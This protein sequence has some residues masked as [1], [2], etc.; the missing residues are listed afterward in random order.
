MAIKISNVTVIDNDRKLFTSGGELGLP[1]TIN[2]ASSASSTSHLI[3]KRSGAATPTSFGAYAGNWRS[4]IEV[5]N[6]DSTRMLFLNPPDIATGEENYAHVKSVGGGIQFGVGSNGSTVPLRL[7][8]AGNAAFYGDT[9]DVVG[10]SDQQM[11]FTATDNSWKYIGFSRSDVGRRSYFG[12]DNSGNPIWGSDSGPFT[13]TGNY[14][15]IGTATHSPIF[16]DSNNTTYYLDPDAAVSGYSLFS[17]GIVVAGQGGFQSRSYNAGR[18]RIWSFNNA[19]GYGISYFQGSGGLNGSDSIGIHFGNAT[20][21]TSVFNFATS[22]NALVAKASF[23]TSLGGGASSS[24]KHID[25]INGT[26]YD[27]FMLPRG[28]L[29][30]YNPIVNDGDAIIGFSAGSVNTGA[31]S[32]I[33]WSDTASGIRLS[34]T[35]VT[36]L[37]SSS[38]NQLSLIGND[39]WAGIGWVDQGGSDY[40]WYRGS[41]ST[42]SIGGS[43]SVV[44]GKKLHING[45]TSIGNTVGGTAV[46]ANSLLVEESV[47]AR[48]FYD[49]DNTNYYTD[50]ADVSIFN[51]VRASKL[52][53]T[54]HSLSSAYYQGGATPTTG[55][56]ITTDI[57]YTS[58]NMPTVIIEGYAYGSAVPIHLEIVW[59]SYSDTFV[60]QSYT[61]LG[62]WHPGTV[63]V[64][65]NANGKVCIHLSNNIYYGRFNVR[66]V[67]DT[68][69]QFLENWTVTE[70]TTSGLTRVVTV[71]QVPVYTSIRG[72]VYYTSDDNYYLNPG[73]STS[74]R[75]VGDWRANSS[76]WTGEFSGKIQYHASNWYFQA[77]D[78]FIWRNAGGTNVFYGNQSGDSTSVGSSRAPIFYDSNDTNYYLNPANVSR[79]ADLYIT[80]GVASNY[81]DAAYSF[82][83]IE[84]RERG[85]GGTQDATWATAPRI[86]FHWS[87]VVASQ[88]GVNTN[89][90]IHI[91]NN[92]G[93]G[94]EDLE[95][96]SIYGNALYDRND[97]SFYIDPASN[98]T[99]I[100]VAGAIEQG[101]DFAHPNIE[102]S[103]SGNSTGMVVFKLPGTS[104]NYGMVHMVFDYYEYDSTKTATIVIGGHNWSSGWYNVGCNVVGNLPKQV[105]LGYI[106]GQYCVVFGDESAS[107]TYGTVRLRK[108]HNGS[109]YNNIINLGGAYSVAQVTSG[110]FVNI[111]GDLRELRTPASFI[112]GGPVSGSRVWAGYDSGEA[113]SVSSSNWFRSSGATGWYN[114]TYVGGI[115]MEDATWVR[116]YGNKQFYSQN[117]IQSDS[118]VRA[119]IFYD[120][121]DTSYYTDPHSTSVLKNLS[122]NSTYATGDTNGTITTNR[123]IGVAATRSGGTTISHSDQNLSGTITSADTL[124]VIRLVSGVSGGSYTGTV[125]AFQHSD[126]TKKVGIGFIQHTANDIT[127]IAVGTAPTYGNVGPVGMLVGYGDDSLAPKDTYCLRDIVDHTRANTVRSVGTRYFHNAIHEARLA[128][129][130]SDIDLSKANLFTRTISGA[131]TFTVS[132]IPADAMVATFILDLTNGGSAAITW[133]SGVKWVGGTAPTLTAAGRDVLGFFTHDGGTTWTGLVLGKDVK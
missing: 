121:N 69:V 51:K 117:F 101:S 17:N 86:S 109:F 87:G 12:I 61:N 76:D 33:P 9:F 73:S 46:S 21:D 115:Y 13:I 29:G 133:W 45:A 75:T 39:T 3:I 41:T 65:T 59:Y 24:T 10:T 111:T 85:F 93:T 123:Y 72:T 130:A 27:L 96:A 102:W 79:I 131:T 53:T 126:T 4:G 35:G 36:T 67:V 25:L 48:I 40:T 116:V 32:I 38:D 100:Q 49:R 94:P 34:S 128:I 103:A 56:L 112:A 90:R 74:L 47:T 107:W 37:R 28:G 105:R 19:D 80:G 44:S 58:F 6:N 70:A 88:I 30:T 92:P 18:N 104:S 108:I 55:Y 97:T 42:F 14:T 114:A 60:S 95:A 71:S 63:T 11:T 82:A 113:N 83:A 22:P 5:W 1:P 118:S 84:V 52:A 77:A 16:Y 89:G 78:S 66:C 124:N 119:P 57:P 81:N 127:A 106:D 98:T 120:S 23:I 110:S 50:P 99:S 129:A 122:I 31:L 64:A 54:Y 15:A 8:G 43:G 91:L 2:T 26:G 7:T 68:G 62:T 20:A 125:L 132:N